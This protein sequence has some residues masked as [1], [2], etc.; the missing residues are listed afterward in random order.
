MLNERQSTMSATARLSGCLVVALL[1]SVSAC[2]SQP[3]GKAETVAE[4]PH[5]TKP[6]QSPGSV[7]DQSKKPVHGAGQKQPAPRK[8][9]ASQSVPTPSQSVPKTSSGTTHSSTPTVPQTAPKQKSQK[10]QSPNSN[11]ECAKVLSGM[12]NAVKNS[13]S[14]K[15]IENRSNPASSGPMQTSYLD[16]KNNFH[17][18]FQVD[19]Q[20]HQLLHVDGKMYMTLTKHGIETVL[21]SRHQ[22]T[23]QWLVDAFAGKWVDMQHPDGGPALKQLLLAPRAGRSFAGVHSP[24]RL[25]VPT[26]GC[27]I[28]AG[29]NGTIKLTW[30][31]QP[32]YILLQSAPSYLPI[33]FYFKDS[34]S[35]SPGTSNSG[36]TTLKYSEWNAVE[37]P[38]APSA[39]ALVSPHAV[40][41]R[42][43]GG[44]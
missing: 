36:T 5:P 44:R 33:E 2:G 30:E 4:V 34:E 26:E 9:T 23:P 38:Q 3:Q 25:R 13:H 22:N 6:E 19:G 39:D 8:T 7:T 29:A 11:P 35:G 27:S 14:V 31:G 20:T 28:A 32:E 1:S 41:E 24:E 15:V 17:E 40:R 18:V 10:Q 16:R 42:A 21:L 37:K 12:R 43:F